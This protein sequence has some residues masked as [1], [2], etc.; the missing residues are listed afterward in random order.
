MCLKGRQA[1]VLGSN[2]IKDGGYKG[3]REDYGQKMERLLAK[4]TP[5]FKKTMI[6]NKTKINKRDGYNWHFK[7]DDK[8][9]R[10]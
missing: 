8:L 7:V 2:G 9:Q 4:V 5:S 6:F 3:E 1:I 10:K